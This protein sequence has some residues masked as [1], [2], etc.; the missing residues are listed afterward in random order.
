MRLQASTKASIFWIKSSTLEKEPGVNTLPE[1]IDTLG[2]HVGEA[3][4][5]LRDLLT[6]VTNFNQRSY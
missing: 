2:T 5:L 1:S 4:S 3:A 6:S